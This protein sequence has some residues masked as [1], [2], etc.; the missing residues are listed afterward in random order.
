MSSSPYF[1]HR[2][3]P[4]WWVGLTE[5]NWLKVTQPVCF[6]F[7][8]N[9][10]RKQNR[11]S[12][13]TRLGHIWNCKFMWLCSQIDRY[14]EIIHEI[15]ISY[16]IPWSSSPV[17]SWINKMLCLHSCVFSRSSSQTNPEHYSCCF[18]EHMAERPAFR[19]V[20]PPS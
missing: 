14:A 16:K 6:A 11:Q 20:S 1:T 12:L 9:A 13:W 5:S 17:K 18:P 19:R 3:N 15:A 7:G 4:V 10:S 8:E 2:N